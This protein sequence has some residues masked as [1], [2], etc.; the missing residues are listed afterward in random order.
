MNQYTNF[1]DNYI[2]DDL[3]TDAEW[4][5]ACEKFGTDNPTRDQVQEASDDLTYQYEKFMEAAGDV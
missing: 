4:E 2:P 5:Y 3:H 1:P